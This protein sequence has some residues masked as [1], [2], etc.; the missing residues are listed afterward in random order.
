MRMLLLFLCHVMRYNKKQIDQ[1][2]RGRLKNAKK[3]FTYPDGGYSSYRMR[4]EQF[5]RE[6]HANCIGAIHGD[7]DGGEN[8]SLHK[9]E[10]E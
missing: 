9:D 7:T 10:Y 2:W 5:G 3:K 4:E 6:D 8:R 1:I